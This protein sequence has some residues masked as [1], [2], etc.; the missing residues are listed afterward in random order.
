MPPEER[1]EEEQ[2]WLTLLAVLLLTVAAAI[3]VRALGTTLFEDEV[4]VANLLRRGH[5]T[6]HSYNVPPLFY[7]IGLFWAQVRGV[8]DPMLREPAAIF[9]VLTAAVPLFAPRPLR[10]RLVWATLLAFSSPLIFY[11]TRLKQYTL[12]CF[13]VTLLLVLFLRAWEGDRRRDW[14]AFFCVAFPSV[15]VLHT[16]V[17]IAASAGLIVL[18]TRRT[19]RAALVAGFLIVGA[20]SVA[21][22]FFYMAPGPETTRLHGDMTVWFTVTGRWV[23]SPASLVSNTAH[24]TGQAFNLVSFWWIAVGGMLL[25]W[26][27]R[28]RNLALLALAALPPLA[29]VVAST[30][31]LYPYG[32]TRLMLFCFP[33]VF[34]IVA[35]ALSLI[36]S[37]SILALM[38]LIPFVFA[39][40]A[41]DPYNTTYMQ[42]DDLRDL[43]ASVIGGLRPGQKVFADPS[44]AAP[45]RYYAPSS[46]RI[47]FAAVTSPGAPG[48]YVQR[49][50]RFSYREADL[51]I[52]SGS[53]VA[54]RIDPVPP[55]PLT[56]GPGVSADQS[57][58]KGSK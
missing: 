51:A 30:Q 43:Y 56:I 11:S 20:A 52:R 40:I 23:N 4:W 46:A 8:S 6:P 37:R 1:A 18:L 36:S 25:F 3:R 50:G 19:R 42:V 58:S 27:A 39:A 9:G 49:A 35:E 57:L 33:A 29:V 47:E 22:Y 10:V 44:Y 53:V 28:E 48:W 24:W 7:W 5:L 16:P 54:V 41:H 38:L 21:A 34:L 15:L 31:H 32:E 13:A 26:I 17:F 2:Q 12:E 45:L 55:P 14:I